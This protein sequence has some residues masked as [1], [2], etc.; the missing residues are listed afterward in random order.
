MHTEIS[1]AR[2]P[3][4]PWVIFNALRSRDFRLY[5]FGMFASVFGL[6]TEFVALG[7]LVLMLT[8][9]PLSLGG[10]G[11][12][13]ALPNVILSLI[14][15]TLA[16]RVD[17]RWLLV[18][19]HTFIAALFIGLG[20]LVTTELVQVWHVY[21]FAVLL[22][23]TRA[24]ESPMRQALIA[25]IVPKEDIGSAVALV[26]VVWQLPRLVGPAIAGVMIAT[27]GVGPTFYVSGAGIFT[28]AVL[29]GLMDIGGVAFKTRERSFF[30]SMVEGLEFIRRS[31]I[32]TALIGLTFFDS[33]FGMS[34]STLLPVFARDILGAGSQGLGLLYT[35]QACGGL[36]GILL[37]A[38]LARGGHRGWSTLLGS[39]A[40]GALI[41]CFALSPWFPFSMLVIVFIGLTHEI[42][43]T[44][45]NTVL[46][47]SVPDEYRGRVMGVYGLAWSIVPLGGVFS[48]GIAEYAGAPVAV[49]LGGVLVLGLALFVTAVPRVRQL[50]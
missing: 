38:R 47:L 17:R 48:G 35:A 41:A 36:V 10:V 12:A 3:A 30:G 45:I 31:P 9:S 18:S 39:G 13:R 29:F 1:E 34:Y 42:Y 24:F 6:T 11:L 5:W 23:S 49:A 14:G 4:G 22:G 15:G 44:V 27:A 37:A 40:Y 32:L 25:Q 43:M 7:W 46:L 50:D 19:T 26:N 21:V 20:M 8:N 28:A 33:V 16:D 2:V